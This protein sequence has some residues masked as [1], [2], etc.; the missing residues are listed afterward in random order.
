MAEGRVAEI[1]RERQRLGE[2]LVETQFAGDRAGDLRHLDAVGEPGAVEI[3]L[4]VDEDLGFVL[5]LA[6]GAAVDDAVAV[7]L[8][9]RARLRLRLGVQATAGGILAHGPAGQGS[10]GDGHAR[11]NTP[12]PTR[13]QTSQGF[14]PEA[15]NPLSRRTKGIK[16]FASFFKKKT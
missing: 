15:T 14:K 7:A 4:V 5:E 10:G 6:E 12:V 3:A 13:L 8:P 16:V 9:G 2:I 1:M 11:A